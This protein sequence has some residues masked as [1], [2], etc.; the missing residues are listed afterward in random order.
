MKKLNI[1]TVILTITLSINCT[2]QNYKL[3]LLLKPGD[4]L[5]NTKDLYFFDDGIDCYLRNECNDI[6]TVFS[7]SATKIHVTKDSVLKYNA[8]LFTDEYE[9]VYTKINKVEG[10]MRVDVPITGEQKEFLKKFLSSNH[11]KDY[12]CYVEIVPFKN[13]NQIFISTIDYWFIGNL[14]KLSATEIGTKGGRL[15][16]CKMVYPKNC[17]KCYIDLGWGQEVW[18]DANGRKKKV[19]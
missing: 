15:E 9:Y 3:N 4:Y 18:Y 1:I 8:Y 17:V 19:K 13:P 12:S 11:F 7:N 2:A 16:A 14:N 6:D 5:F 10:W